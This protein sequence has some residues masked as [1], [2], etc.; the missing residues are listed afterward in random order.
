M[1]LAL[2]TT[3]VPL[4]GDPDG[5]VRVA[6]TR[7]T[8]DTV[9]AAFSEGATPEEIAQQYSVLEL[10]DVYSV[11]GFY[12]N[13]KA[14]VDTYLAERRAQCERV[15]RENEAR[16]NPKGVRERLLARRQERGA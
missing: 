1:T 12:L 15:R 5:V 9:V 13:R 10:G 4:R 16:F 3:P 6:E 14:E 11:I 7:V 8:L 2:E